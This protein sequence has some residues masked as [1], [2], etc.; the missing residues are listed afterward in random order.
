MKEE[1]DKVLI[2]IADYSP[3]RN[4]IAHSMFV[5]AVGGSG[6]EFHIVR[7][8]GKLDVPSIVWTH[9]DFANAQAKLL[10]FGQAVDH[11]RI[12]VHAFR[13]DPPRYSERLAELADRLIR[14]L[15]EPPHSDPS[16]TEKS[17]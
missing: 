17:Q 3:T 5:G 6:V 10:R 4:M 11:I 9:A 16:T 15:R 1:F 12:T 13:D 2:K 8:R 7:A 14:P